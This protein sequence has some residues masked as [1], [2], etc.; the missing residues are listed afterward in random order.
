MPAG[1][2]QNTR[3]SAVLY[4]AGKEWPAHA[5]ELPETFSRFAGIRHKA[6]RFT[7]VPQVRE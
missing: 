7:Y 3:A 2:C 4:V 5:A 6:D 1:N